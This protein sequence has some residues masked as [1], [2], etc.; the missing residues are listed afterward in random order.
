[1]ISIA[2]CLWAPNQYSES[3]STMYDESWVEKLYRG[4]RR[5]LTQPMELVCFVDRLREFREPIRQELLEKAPFHYGSCIEPFK[6]N[7]P[8]IFAGLDTVVVGNV[9]HF[10]DYCFTADRM[11]C[12]RD[13]F[14]P[15]RG[16]C[17][18]IVL[19][20]A[21]HGRMW[22][23]FPGGNDMAWLRQQDPA[24]MDDI[25]PGE[26]VSYKGHVKD[27]GI[28]GARIVIFHGQLKPHELDEP[29]IRE[30]WT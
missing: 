11:A 23:E 22:S 25:W 4:F 26:V 29:W 30:H 17:N 15:D 16:G 6:L 28:D 12:P 14:Y 1:M 20:P 2:C 8:M 24:I 21:G 3:F 13:P 10:A 7:R 27:Y 9:D 19:T 18:G 5:N